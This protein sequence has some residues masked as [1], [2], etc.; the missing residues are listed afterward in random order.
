MGASKLAETCK[1]YCFSNTS[2][3]RKSCQHF[4][5]VAPFFF[6]AK[7]VCSGN[8]SLL[9]SWGHLDVD[10]FLE[11][12]LPAVPGH[13]NHCGLIPFDGVVV[14]PCQITDFMHRQMATIGYLT[15]RHLGCAF[16]MER[17]GGKACILDLTFPNLAACKMW[18]R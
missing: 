7:V 16:G 15:N 18:T 17:F 10:G 5:H 1:I 14:F 13:V 12:Q 2:V 11:Q 9:F 8:V 6:R 3:V 4:D